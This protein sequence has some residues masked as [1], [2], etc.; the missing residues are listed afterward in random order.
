MDVHSPGFQLALTKAGW[1]QDLQPVDG[2]CMAKASHR[3]AYPCT[4]VSMPLRSATMLPPRREH[5]KSAHLAKKAVAKELRQARRRTAAEF[6]SKQILFHTRSTTDSRYTHQ[7]SNQYGYAFRSFTVF[8]KEAL[9]G[10]LQRTSC[11]KSQKAVHVRVRIPENGSS[12]PARRGCRASP[13]AGSRLGKKRLMLLE[14][15]L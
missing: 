2:M 8:M 15:L 5:P 6:S 1:T 7:G 10:L 13:S 9:H 4:S 11:K 12:R 3:V 14:P